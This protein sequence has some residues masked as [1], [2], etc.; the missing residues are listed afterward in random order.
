MRRYADLDGLRSTAAAVRADLEARIAEYGRRRD[1]M[2]Q[3]VQLLSADYD[4]RKA[5]LARDPTANALAEVEAKIKTHEQ[6]VFALREC[7][8]RGGG[9]SG[10]MLVCCYSLD[11]PR[12]AAQSSLPKAARRTTSPCGRSA[13]TSWRSSTHSSSGRSWPCPRRQLAALH[14]RLWQARVWVACSR[15]ADFVVVCDVPFGLQ[16]FSDSSS[17]ARS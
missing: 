12:C 4:K 7:A 8:C 2:R 13:C 6:N 10:D 3:Q 15:R 11:A 17:L 16:L 9:G 1:M 5:A 14:W